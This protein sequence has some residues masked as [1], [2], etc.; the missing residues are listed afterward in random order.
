MTPRLSYHVPSHQGPDSGTGLAVRGHCLSSPQGHPA[1]HGAAR[2]ESSQGSCHLSYVKTGAL[3]G[4]QGGR[5]R[6]S[7]SVPLAPALSLSTSI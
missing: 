1:L 3:R 7:R 4:H 5:M 6:I 2:G